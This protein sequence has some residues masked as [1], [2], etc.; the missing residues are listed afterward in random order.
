MAVD[1]AVEAA[2]VPAALDAP[3][4]DVLIAWCQCCGCDVVPM[5]DGRCGWC[6]WP[7]LAGIEAG[8]KF[9]GCGNP[10]K[11]ES[12]VCRACYGAQ[13]IRTAAI[14]KAWGLYGQGLT[15][16]AVARAVVDETGYTSWRSCA[17]GLKR[18]FA[19]RGWRLRPGS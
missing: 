2:A 3:G 15:L 19:A 18:H 10:K 13:S 1:V 8:P 17:Q 7:V 12:D 6:D 9:C 14:E 4:S 16:A 5:D 11:P